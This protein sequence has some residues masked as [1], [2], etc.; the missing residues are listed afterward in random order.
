MIPK[1]SVIIPVHNVESYLGKCLD[2]VCN[3]SLKDI[4]IICINDGSTDHS[5][6][7]LQNYAKQ[8]SRI[9]II[10][11]KNHGI[12]YSRNAGFNQAKG[13]YIYYLDSD[14]YITT[15]CL[16]L[17][18]DKMESEEL[19]VL[20]FNAKVFG[21]D[22]VEEKRILA[23]EKYFK[24]NHDYPAKCSG[25][26]LFALCKVNQEYIAPVSTQM[27]ARDFLCKNGLLFYNGIIHED[28]LYTFQC[29]LLAAKAGYLN[30]RLY[31][32]RVRNGSLMDLNQSEKMIFSVYSCFICLKEMIRFC[33]ER[34]FQEQNR[35]TVFSNIERIASDC[36]NRYEKLNEDDRGKVLEIT[37]KDRFFLD[38][39]VLTVFNSSERI[40]LFKN[41]TEDAKKEL[42]RSKKQAANLSRD[43]KNVKNGWSYKIGRKITWLPRKLR[44]WSRRS[45]QN[46]GKL[47]KGESAIEPYAFIRVKNEAITLKASLNSI[48]PVIKK[49]VIAYN[50]CTDGSDLII[51]EFCKRNPGFIPFHYPYHVV[52]SNSPDY[53]TD[54][55]PY[56]NT[57]AAYYNAALAFIPQNS[58]M[59]KIDCDQIYF[60]DILKKSFSLPKNNFEVVVYSRLNLVRCNN[61]V[62]VIE[63]MRPGDHWLIYNNNLKFI[64]RHGYENNGEY[65]A[66]EFL[67]IPKEYKILYKPECSSFHFPAEKSYRILTVNEDKLMSLEQ[68]R[69]IAD[70]KEISP[71]LL[72]DKVIDKIISSFEY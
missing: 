65:Y 3:Q 10:N 7:I 64:N 49:G 4:E 5:L 15:D 68:F 43:L 51:Q 19:E 32:R 26:E 44:D 55:I 54:K 63:Y 20:L 61:S 48:L 23:D 6:Q 17:L 36:R 57:L 56:E 58:W 2:S 62:K 70:P 25:E 11:Q 37:G 41:E 67:V 72:E 12:S 28:E 40:K 14:D 9:I 50:E 52:E 47:L 33:L 21:D 46:C 29:L 59:I 27:Y 53:E 24:R 8:D 39:F 34:D 69:K 18:A 31:F 13:T 1:V 60:P 16:E 71:G 22:G 38:F 30:K 66:W 45:K 42:Q 35:D